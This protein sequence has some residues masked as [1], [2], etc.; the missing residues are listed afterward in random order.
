M[1]VH[2]RCSR[3]DVLEAAQHIW[4]EDSRSHCKLCSNL[5]MKG[6]WPSWASHRIVPTKLPFGDSI[7]MHFGIHLMLVALKGCCRHLLRVPQDRRDASF[8]RRQADGSEIVATTTTATTMS[9]TI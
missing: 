7:C 9:L 3:L 4:F 6:C 8:N 2:Q 1:F 5:L